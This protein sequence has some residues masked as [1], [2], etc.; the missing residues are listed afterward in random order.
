MDDLVIAKYKEELDWTKDIRG[1]NIKIY[2]KSKDIPNIG[3]EAETYIRY[4]LENY[5][6]LPNLIC[7]CQGNPF[8]HEPDFLKILNKKEP[9]FFGKITNDNEV[10]YPNHPGLEIGKTYE[11]IFGESLDIFRFYAGAQ[12]IVNKEQ[13]LKH[14]L[15]FYKNINKILLEEEQ[16][17]WCL[18]RIWSYIFI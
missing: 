17:P 14:P 4:I 1:W 3:R 6:N 15:K 5:K 13:I 18:E 11:K 2:D 10:G 9:C 7:F 8:D 16:A 12:F